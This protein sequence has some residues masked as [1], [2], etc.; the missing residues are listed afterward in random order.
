M[1]KKKRYRSN[2][3]EI[4]WAERNRNNRSRIMSR[5]YTYASKYT[6]EI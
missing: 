3:K 5:S 6:T 2:N 4:M 1:E